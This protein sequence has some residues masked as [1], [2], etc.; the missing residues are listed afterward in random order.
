MLTSSKAIS[1]RQPALR[2]NELKNDA[3]SLIWF[4]L[5]RERAGENGAAE[6]EAKAAKLKRME[7]PYPVIELYLGGRSP[8]EVLSVASKADERC[9]AQFYGGEWHLLRGHRAEAAAALQAAVDTCQKNFV[10][11]PGAFGLPSK[12]ILLE[13]NA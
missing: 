13:A 7:W 2:A 6:L 5:S 9:E 12:I 1:G 4:Y 8:A 3:Y 10:E 11:Y